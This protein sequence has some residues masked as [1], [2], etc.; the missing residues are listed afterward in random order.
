MDRPQPVRSVR[1]IVLVGQMATG[2]TTVGRLLADELGW[3]FIDSDQQLVADTGH[4]GRD[5]AR[6]HG[7]DELHRLELEMFESAYRHGEPVVV[8]VA[9][10][11]ID[12]RKARQMLSRAACVWLTADKAVQER[13]RLQGSHRR[14]VMPEEDLAA[15]SAF[16]EEVADLTVDTTNSS[17]G[18]C[19]RRIREGFGI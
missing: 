13:R 8:A 6:D 15:R 2:K 5:I 14:Q 3:P 11:V 17:A 10:S 7:V 16:F 4:E 12:H 19:V 9:A 1:K 18:E